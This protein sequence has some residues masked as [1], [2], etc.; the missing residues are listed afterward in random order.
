M[1]EIGNFDDAQAVDINDRGQV[2][3]S[4]ET[5]APMK[6]FFTV[7]ASC[8]NSAASVASATVPWHLN[9]LGP[10]G[11]HFPADPTGVQHAFF[12]S[13]DD[14]RTTDLTRWLMNSFGDVVSVNSNREIHLN[15]LGQIALVAN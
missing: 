1:T 12:Y 15:D 7:R 2:L 6:P 4:P 10:G 3:G 8:T 9:E 13:D 14:G 11:R 5:L